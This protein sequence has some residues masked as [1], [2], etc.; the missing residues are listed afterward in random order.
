MHE[1]RAVS[2]PVELRAD[3][4]TLLNEYERRLI[5]LA[6]EASGGNQ[7]RAAATLGVLPTTLSEKIKRLGLRR[8]FS[9]VRP[10]TTLADLAATAGLQLG[11]ALR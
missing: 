8:S 1:M 9:D 3:L 6:L 7:R 10:P 4:K 11:D 5:Q 2:R